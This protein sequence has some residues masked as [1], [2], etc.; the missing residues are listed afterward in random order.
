LLIVVSAPSGA[1]KTTIC[2][3][4]LGA[5]RRMV[6]SVS[7]TTR[8]PRHHEV[9]GRDYHFLSSERFEQ[10]IS[11]GAFLEH[12]TV[13]GYRYGTLRAPVVEALEGGR[14]VLMDIDVQGAANVRRAAHDAP[15]DDPIRRAFLDIFIRPPSLAELRRRLAQRATDSPAVIERRLANAQ[16]ELN[17]ASEYRYVV[18]NDDLDQAVAEIERILDQERARRT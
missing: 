16:A 14:D 9:D 4:L 15:P 7:C 2:H 12:A 5:H 3:R 1:G 8:P 17:R 10:L 18:V 6:Y 11:A 13:H